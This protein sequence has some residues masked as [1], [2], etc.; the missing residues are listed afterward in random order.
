[1]NKKGFTLVEIVVTISILSILTAITIPTYISWLPKHR[2]Q[3]SVRQIYD[4]LNLAKM[5][6]VRT[7][8]VAVAIFYPFNNTYSIF[9]DKSDP[10]NYAL[11]ASD[12]SIR[13]G[14]TLENGTNLYETTAPVGNTF[15]FNNRGLLT[16]GAGQIHLKSQNGL[17]LGVD[18]N[19]AGGLNIIKSTDN[20]ATWN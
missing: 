4:D 11:D 18:L 20:G 7:N 13:S 19:I 10:V 8:T 16:T 14:A 12:T 5:E 17:Y 1:M 2:L 9:L 6:A 3:T 15:G